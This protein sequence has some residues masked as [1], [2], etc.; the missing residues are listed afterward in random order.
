MGIAS[1]SSTDHDRFSR[2]HPQLLELAMPLSDV[3]GS[4]GFVDGNGKDVDLATIVKDAPLVGLYFSAHWCGPCRAFTPKLVTFKAMLSEDGIDFPIVFASSDRDEAA[5][6]EYFATMTGF[7]AFKHGDE[8]IKSLNSK[9]GV[10]GI[11]WLV[12]LDSEGNL[13]LNE[14]DTEVGQGP[15]AYKKW[16]AKAKAQPAA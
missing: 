3:M 5:M 16:L 2:A 4:A 10:S 7:S 11:P 9:F 13:V 6:K 15:D 12:V 1:T 8:R 14:A